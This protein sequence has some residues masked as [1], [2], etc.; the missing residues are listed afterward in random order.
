MANAYTAGS[1][2]LTEN[3]YTSSEVDSLIEGAVKGGVQPK[4]SVAFASLP[5]PS[6]ANVGHMYN[7]TDAFT[8]TAAWVEGAGKNY[9]AHTN[10]YV[11]NPSGTTYKW[12]AL[13]GEGPQPATAAPAADGTA[14]VGSSLRYA[15]EDHVHPTDT[16]RA[17]A[18]ALTNHTGNTTVHV[19]AAERTAWNAKQAKIT[20]NGLLKGDGTGA[21]TAATAGTDY[22]VPSA[23]SGYVPTTRTVNGKALSSDVTISGNDIAPV[24]P[25]A[26][27]SSSNLAN[28][29]AF[30]YNQAGAAQSAAAAAQT[31]A[32]GAA[33]NASAALT[34]VGAI[35]AAAATLYTALNG[36]DSDSMTSANAI[37][38][39]VASLL[40]YVKAFAAAADNDS[41]TTYAPAS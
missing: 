4:G 10:V 27:T 6:A 40:S 41:M 8:T 17:A 21:V 14:A 13:P 26:E 25:V 5:A 36:L 30:V 28:D 29:V 15:R 37:K 11:V 24:L 12:D 19:T 7:V 1:I 22:V 39:L 32:D 18:S 9:P 35:E 3:V 20:A 33:S 38:T 23:L 16:T 34:R 31:T 2:P